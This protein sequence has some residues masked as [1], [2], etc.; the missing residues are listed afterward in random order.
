MAN[1]IG[2]WGKI[3]LKILASQGSMSMVSLRA[4]SGMSVPDFFDRINPMLDA[5]IL[6]KKDK[7]VMLSEYGE[8]R[9][10]K[11]FGGQGEVV[12]EYVS[13]VSIPRL[14]TTELFIPNKLLFLRGRPNVDK[15][16]P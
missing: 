7:R 10:H 6:V 9:V 14:S 8:T 16:K 11:L 15:M 1:Y 2:K 4:K 13:S 5:G 12:S 3:I